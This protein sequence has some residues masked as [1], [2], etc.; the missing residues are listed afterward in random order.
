MLGEVRLPLLPE[1]T[2]EEWLLNSVSAN[3]IGA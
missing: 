2:P 1:Q 3:A